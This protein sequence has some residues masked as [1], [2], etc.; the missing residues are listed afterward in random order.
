[1]GIKAG[2]GIKAGEGIKAGLSII[3]KGILKFSYNLFAGVCCWRKIEETD[4]IIECGKLET[5]GEIR[6]GNLTEMGNFEEIEKI[7]VI[8]GKKYRLIEGEKL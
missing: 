8:D 6:Q 7:K 2:W 3:C 4:L 5:D 1:M